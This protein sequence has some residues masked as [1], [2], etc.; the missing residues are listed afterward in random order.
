MQR[1]VN[2]TVTQQKSA[3]TPKRLSRYEMTIDI[4]RDKVMD[5][6]EKKK[7]TTTKKV[8][9]SPK[10]IPK[11]KPENVPNKIVYKRHNPNITEY[12]HERGLYTQRGGDVPLKPNLVMQDPQEYRKEMK[13]HVYNEKLFFEA[14]YSYRLIM[15]EMG[16]KW[17][18][19]EKL[20]VKDLM[21]FTPIDAD[22]IHVEDIAKVVDYKEIVKR[23]GPEEDTV[24]LD[25][26]YYNI[27][28]ISDNTNNLDFSDC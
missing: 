4:I 21:D 9:T 27:V 17:F 15:K 23:L 6:E 2:K 8:N 3:E 13:K 18:P 12:S 16:F 19:S 20:W 11:Q 1:S 24:N 5:N 14:P 7:K 25:E 28:D 22:R 26:S 10:H